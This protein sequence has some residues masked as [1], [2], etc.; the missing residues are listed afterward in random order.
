MAFQINLPLKY[1]ENIVDEEVIV[2]ASV[3]RRKRGGMAKRRDGGGGGGGG[4][5]AAVA[6]GSRE[7]ERENNVMF[8]QPFLGLRATWINIQSAVWTSF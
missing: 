8:C 6:K 3:R 5:E 4:G 2:V 7:R 1:V